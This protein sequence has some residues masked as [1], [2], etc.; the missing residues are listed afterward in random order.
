MELF[1][2]ADLLKGF[3]S[4]VTF[5][6]ISGLMGLG[7]KN[8]AIKFLKKNLPLIKDDFF[9]NTEIILGD[10]SKDIL[11]QFKIH[12]KTYYTARFYGIDIKVYSD[13]KHVLN[14]SRHLSDT[15]KFNTIGTFEIQEF[16]QENFD[17]NKLRLQYTLF[18]ETPFGYDC[19]VKK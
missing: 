3:L 1:I 11:I 17:K 7:L 18:F 6:I 9:I 8:F 19:I 13:Y 5:K 15:I 12:N 2:N 14:I 10:G 16:T 4:K